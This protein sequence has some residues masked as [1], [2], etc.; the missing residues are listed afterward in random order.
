MAREKRTEKGVEK[1]DGR[2]R[3][4]QGRFDNFKGYVQHNLKREEKDAYDAWEVSEEWLW[5]HV[6]VMVDN[7]YK[8]SVS[9][10]KYNSTY[11]CS[12][13]ANGVVDGNSGWVLVA[14]APDCYNAMR[15]LLFKHFILMESDWS[16]FQERPAGDKEWG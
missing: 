7:L 6:E 8:I 11:Q 3:S 14:R 1:G 2:F 5:E 13:T 9:Y 12:A 4:V 15:L 10:D 16:A